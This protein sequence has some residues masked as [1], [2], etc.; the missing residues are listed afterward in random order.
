MRLRKRHDMASRRQAPAG[1]QVGLCDVDGA[2][3]QKFTE[4]IQRVFVLAAGE[5][6]RQFLPHLYVSL[7]IF[8]YDRLFVP[9]Q[10]EFVQ[11]SS[12]LQRLG[13]SVCMIGVDHQG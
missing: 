9:A 8:G 7:N 4:T 6:Y 13:T 10:I 11:G 1:S 2:R 12:K 5:L 3:A